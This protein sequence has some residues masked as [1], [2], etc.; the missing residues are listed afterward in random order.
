MS[1]T[2]YSKNGLVVSTHAGPAD[3]IAPNSNSRMR[4]QISSNIVEPK[5]NYVILNMDEWIDL[6]CFI[7]EMDNYGI[8]ILDV[9]EIDE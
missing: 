9:N 1:T 5:L 6:V 3:Q 4:I 7:R 8:G 2:R